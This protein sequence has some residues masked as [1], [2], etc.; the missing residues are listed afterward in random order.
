[1]KMIIAIV[2]NEDSHAVVSALMEAKYEVTKL[3]TTGGF[4]KAG[5]TT[6]LIGTEDEK[7]Q[8]CLDILK[9]E[10]SKRTEIV[11]AASSYEAG[12][13]ASYPIKVTVGGA[14][15]FILDVEQFYKF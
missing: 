14:I 6:L 9:Q 1:M 10:S 4:L 13:F 7:V 5:N 12:R 2:S 15:V 11:P 3:A 8:A